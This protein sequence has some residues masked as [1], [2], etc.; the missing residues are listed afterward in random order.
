MDEFRNRVEDIS[1]VRGAFWYDLHDPSASFSSSFSFTTRVSTPFSVYW[2]HRDP[3]ISLL[4]LHASPS[5]SLSRPGRVVVG[6][7]FRNQFLGL[8]ERANTSFGIHSRAEIAADRYRR[9]EGEEEELD[10]R[11]ETWFRGG[12]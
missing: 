2:T 10:G 9:G 3:V 8:L 4:L 12:G 7:S 6:P 5:V 11:N 1:S